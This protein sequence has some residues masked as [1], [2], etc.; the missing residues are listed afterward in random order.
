MEAKGAAVGLRSLPASQVRITL[1]GV[2]LAM[3]LGSLDQTIVGTAMPSIIADLGGFAQYTWVTTAYIIT[4]A[5]AIPITGK[6]TDM[7][8]RKLFYIA[9]LIIFTLGS[10][11]TGLS[12]TM[13]QIIIFRGFQGIGAGVMIANAFT[14][15]GDLF[16]P[17]ERGHYQ[18]IISAVFGLSSIIG[19]IVGGFI[20]D[21]LSWHWV[22]FINIPLG[23]LIISL[24]FLFFPN[25]KPNVHHHRVDYPGVVTLVLAVVPLMLA[26]SFGG[27]EYEWDSPQIIAMFVFAAVMTAVF[28]RIESRS[29]EP[30]IPLALFRNKIIAVSELVVFFTTFG[31]FGSIVFIPLFFQGVLGLSATTS[32]SFLTPMMLG[33]VFGSFVSGQALVR[34]G[35]HYRIQGAIGLAIMALGLALLS[36]MSVR[37][38]YGV[39]V[40]NI[41]LF[42]F[43]LGITLPLYTIAIQNTVPYSQLGAATASVPFF[44]SIGGSV[45][46][47]LLGSVMNNRFATLFLANI[48]DAARNLVPPQQL[49]NLA[50]NPQVLV[51]AEAQSQLRGLLENL[52]AQGAALFDQIVQVLRSSLGSALSLVF[53]M[54]LVTVIIG[55]VLNLFI[56]EVPLRKQHIPPPREQDRPHAGS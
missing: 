24:F 22:F 51:S 27:V 15:I 11:L 50:H 20:T 45:G 42:G 53:L 38:P 35:G 56:T 52:G 32:G 37:T 16:P 21:A 41:A 26:L 25:F 44:R 4:S 36:L 33:N 54:A 49:E 48:P 7:Y 31:M 12:Q 10:L 47:A 46:L 23:I 2:L 28:L 9:G 17:A 6:L 18:G 40:V 43:G 39:A 5:V 55:F 3:F 1:I 8:G 30:I 29:A 19:P 34:T 13:A 14:V